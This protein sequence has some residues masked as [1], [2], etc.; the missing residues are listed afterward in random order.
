MLT[1]AMQCYPAWY[2]KCYTMFAQGWYYCGWTVQSDEKSDYERGDIIWRLAA[3]MPP[4]AR[5]DPN[6]TGPSR[7]LLGGDDPQDR[8]GRASPLQAGGPLAGGKP[9]RRAGRPGRL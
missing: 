2:K 6:R 7:R 3:G 8:G 5:S 1:R 9:G 4:G